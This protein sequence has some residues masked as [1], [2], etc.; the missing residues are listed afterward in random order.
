MPDMESLWECPKC[1]A[2]LI[3]RNLS[4]SCGDYSVEKFLNGKGERARSLFYLFV[5]LIENCGPFHVAP[6]KTRVA[7]MALV[8]FAS[9]NRVS[10]GSIDVHFVLPHEIKSPR[11]R[12][13]EH[14][15]NCCVHHLRIT[16][17][18]EFDLELQDWLK[19]SYREY[20]QREWLKR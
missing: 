13:V 9:V 18:D 17:N 10:D 1:G 2:K 8:R 3:T 14:L 11:F 15:A 7:F 5:R 20:G 16:S 19:V 6:A 4:H 12:R